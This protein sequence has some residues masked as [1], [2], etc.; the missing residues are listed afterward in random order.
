MHG[1]GKCIYSNGNVYEGT[2]EKSK[3][4]GQGK[5]TFTDGNQYEGSW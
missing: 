3:R 1:E 2:F 5:Y 4:H